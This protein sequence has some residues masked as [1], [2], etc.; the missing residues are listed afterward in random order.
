MSMDLTDFTY[1]LP[2]TLIAQRP[3]PVRDASRMMVLHRQE[4]RIEHRQFF[5]LPDYLEKGD[6]L[7]VNDSRVIPARLY[8]LKETGGT[9]EVLLLKKLQGAVPDAQTWEVLLRPARRA[10]A[11]QVLSLPGGARAVIRERVSDKKWTVE[12]STGTDFAA[13]LRRNGEAPLPPYIKRRPGDASHFP[14]RDRY[15]TVYA[16]ADGSVA[17][18]TAG[19]HFTPRTFDALRSRGVSIAAVTLHVGYGT[20]LP[21]TASRIEDHVMEEESFEIDAE[22][23]EAINAAKRVVAVGTTATR[24]LESATDE[25]GRIRPTAGATR[26]F[27]Y[28]GY[29]FKRVNRLLTNFH[30]PASSLLLLV[31]AFAGRECILDAYRQAVEACYRF[32]SYGDCML[33]L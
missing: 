13:Y 31:S 17:A 4:R 8:A 29:R 3:C 14:D 9:V 5:E 25:R 12:F 26:L 7:V 1:E 23:A 10:A 18:P 16:R 11:G 28:P 19:L 2:N 20:F 30:L 27:I 33:I 21:V 32:Y 24:V 6:V 15:Q 22:A